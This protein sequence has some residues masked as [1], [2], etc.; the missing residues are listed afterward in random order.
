MVIFCWQ[1][2]KGCLFS[3]CAVAGLWRGQS[4]TPLWRDS[5]AVTWHQQEV[6]CVMVMLSRKLECFLPPII[7]FFC[8]WKKRRANEVNTRMVCMFSLKAWKLSLFQYHQHFYCKSLTVKWFTKV[9]SM[10][11]TCLVCYIELNYDYHFHHHCLL[12]F[13][14]LFLV[15]HVTSAERERR[16]EQ[17][18]ILHH[19][20]LGSIF[21]LL[22]YQASHQRLRHQ[23]RGR[24]HEDVYFPCWCGPY[25]VSPPQPPIM[26]KLPWGIHDHSL[27]KW[28]FC[29][30][31]GLHRRRSQKRVTHTHSSL[32]Q[33][34]SSSCNVCEL[35]L[36]LACISCSFILLMHKYQQT[37]IHRL[38]Q[39]HTTLPHHSALCRN[40]QNVVTIR[41]VEKI[42]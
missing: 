28:S 30:H 26:S 21:Q 29:G 10:F 17:C 7:L 38:T 40:E 5:L 8:F 34:N 23:I 25:G 22:H 15:L 20:W 32:L 41:T 27:D 36:V 18:N 12:C 42:G 4:V 33:C 13:F 14:L 31:W 6:S 1:G 19:F 2:Y 3:S 24:S 16:K 39:H 35:V 9:W 11:C 37:D